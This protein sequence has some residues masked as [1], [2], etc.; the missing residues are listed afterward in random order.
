[1]ATREDNLKKINA[2]LETMS[3]DELSMVA[4]GAKDET[5]GDS[6]LLYEHGLINEWYGDHETHCHWKS[7][8]AEVDAGWAKAGITSVTKPSGDNLYFM[9]GKQIS[10][11]EA[12]NHEIGR[13]HV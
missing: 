1:M 2:E 13:A 7:S 6:I 5:E 11:D 12:W 3:D 8:S 9:G 10:R 4:G